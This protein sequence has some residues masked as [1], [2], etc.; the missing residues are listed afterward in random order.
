[1]GSGTLDVPTLARGPEQY[2]GRDSE[3][4]RFSLGLQIKLVIRK[5]TKV[6]KM[7]SWGSF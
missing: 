2:D 3:P 6:P 4:I 1:M 5:M 7:D